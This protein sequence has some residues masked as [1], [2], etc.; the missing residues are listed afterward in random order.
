MKPKTNKRKSHF[1]AALCATGLLSLGQLHG[2]EEVV[3]V[4]LDPETVICQ[5]F[6]GFG[7]E[8][9]S[10]S[11]DDS[12]VTDADFAV[13]SKRVEWMRLP[14]ARIMM[15]SKWCYKGDGRYDWNDPKLI[16]LCRQLD[17]CSW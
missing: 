17:V 16:A 9:D 2:E 6:P 11:Y 1:F 13:I 15:Q 10:N 8:W 12:G 7:A 14:V 4:R 3:S 5:K